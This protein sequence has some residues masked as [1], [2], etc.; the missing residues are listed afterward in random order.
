MELQ[1]LALKKDGLCPGGSGATIFHSLSQGLGCI[2]MALDVKAI[3]Y[4][5]E[6]QG[7]IVT[8]MTT[9]LSVVA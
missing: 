2:G 5:I 4:K 6:S 9:V 8:G 1:P 7:F 3:T